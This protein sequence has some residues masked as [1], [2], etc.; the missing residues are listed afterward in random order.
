MSAER[1]H[2]GK[3]TRPERPVEMAELGNQIALV[4]ARCIADRR[5]SPPATPAYHAT[6]NDI[7]SQVSLAIKEKKTH[8]V[9]D[10]PAA[11]ELD[12][13]RS[14]TAQ[15]ALKA[16]SVGASPN[17]VLCAVGTALDH[18]AQVSQIPLERVG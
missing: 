16:L 7:H 2:R 4:R 5:G 17:E 9:S 18:A 13:L 1:T 8:I 11:R 12:A 14:T 15:L 6:V 10:S 3:R